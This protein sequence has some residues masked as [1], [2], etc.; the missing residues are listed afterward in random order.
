MRL[1]TVTVFDVSI[2]GPQAGLGKDIC[3]QFILDKS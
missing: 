3:R 2:F 1:N